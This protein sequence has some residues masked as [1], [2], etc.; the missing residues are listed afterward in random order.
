MNDVP[1]VSQELGQIAFSIRKYYR[2]CGL[3]ELPKFW[4]YQ[5]KY[6]QLL[7]KDGKVILAYAEKQSN[8]YNIYLYEGL[9]RII[10]TSTLAHEVLHLWQ[11][12][13]NIV[14]PADLREGFCNLGSYMVMKNIK[15]EDA[16]MRIKMY[17]R[18][19]DPIY[20]DGFRKM[21]NIYDNGGWPAVI[22]FLH[23]THS[24]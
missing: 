4:V 15:T 6:D 5:V 18:D 23:Q 9:S 1:K 8:Y 3:G 13:H 2:E 10:Y 7:K 22:D 20:G 16:I 11:W 21:K 12:E 24:V 14:L 19:T 17:E